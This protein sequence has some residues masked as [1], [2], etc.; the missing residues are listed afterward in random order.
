MTNEKLKKSILNKASAILENPCDALPEE[1][2]VK[3]VSHFFRR[4]DIYLEMVRKNGSPLYLIEKNILK[5][6]AMAFREAFQSV[7]PEVSFYYAVK[8][9]NHPEISRTLIENGFGLDVSSGLELELAI[10]IGATD[11]VFSGPGKT[12]A[13]LSLAVDHSAHVAVLMDS[14]FELSRLERI[15]EKEGKTIRAGVRLTTNEKG[16]W[17]KFGIPMSSIKD[18]L[19]KSLECPHVAVNGFQFHTSWNLNPDQ[20][21]QFIERLGRTIQ[22]LPAQLKDMISFIDI[23]GGYWPTMGEWLQVQGTPAGSLLK[24]LQI[25]SGNDLAHFYM[26]SETIS[27]FSEKLGAAIRQHIFVHKPCRICFEPG[28]WIVNDAMHLLFSVVDKKDVDFVITDAGTNAVGWERYETDYFPVLNLSRP[29]LIEKPCMVSGSL[30]TPH[31]IWGYGYWGEDISAG[32]ILMIPT[33]GAYTYSLR[34][35]FIKS[36]PEVVIIG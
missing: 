29:A 5:D 18:F 31:D 26:P 22:T 25:D 9:N 23:G 7:L 4:K 14:P 12:D 13:E 36:L 20:Q 24:H 3:F 27:N 15:A 8:S 2:L 16:L 30:C 10:S 11:I 34:Q 17:R 1:N 28:R 32:D 19:E 33:Q 35:H 6:R 21:I